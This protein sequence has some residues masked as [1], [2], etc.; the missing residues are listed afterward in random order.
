MDAWKKLEAHSAELKKTNLTELFKN[1]NRFEEFSLQSKDFLLDYSKNIITAETLQLFKELADQC[2]ISSKIKSVFKGDKINWTEGRSVL[3]TALRKPAD[4]SFSVDGVEISKDIHRV[5]DKMEAFSNQVRNGEWKGASGK[6]IS[7]IVNIGIGGSDLGPKM[8]YEALKKYVDGPKAHFVSNVDASDIAMTL[9]E[10]NLEE[11]LFL[12]ASKTFTTQETMTNAFSARQAVIDKLGEESISK[13]FVAMST[14]V[15]KVK[16]FGIDEKNIFEFWDFVGGRYSTWSA[17]GLPLMI[18]LGP[19]N[20]RD[21]LAGGNDIDKQLHD[22]PLQENIPYLLAIL[23]IWYNNFFEAQSHAI[24]PY[25]QYLH[26]FSAHLQQ[27]DMESNGK[28]ID[29]NNSKIDYQT[30]PVIWGEPGTN[31]QHAFYQLIH[32][33]TKLI[34]CDFIGFVQSLNPIGDHHNKLMANYFAQTEALAFGLDENKVREEL[35]KDGLSGEALE[36]LIPHKVFDGNRPTN[37]LLIDR[38]TPRSLGKLLAIYEHKILIQGLFWNV[39][40]F[41]QWGVE[42]GK[43]L[44]KNILKDMD[45]GKAEGHDDST[46]NLVNTYLEKRSKSVFDEN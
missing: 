27:V 42:L 45:C 33:G 44:A 6:K 22:A 21:F 38:L 9:E 43:K 12:I 7:T 17:I 4:E 35:E 25:D 37:S 29:A 40:S 14:A 13:H 8:V 5:L 3:H 18:S 10:V 16:E 28:K 26:R 39:N 30:G 32:Q 23:G 19:N 24:L 15:D 36:N 46:N 11:T 34:P 20:F 2:D 31:G 41:D 1:Q